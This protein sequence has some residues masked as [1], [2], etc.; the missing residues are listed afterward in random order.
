M[1]VYRAIFGKNEIISISEVSET[2][3]LRGLYHYEHKN[4]RLVYAIIN[5]ENEENALT[6]ADIII[7]EV[8]ITVFGTDYVN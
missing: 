2:T 6:I 1:N 3:V 8:S 5:A 7:K 4:G